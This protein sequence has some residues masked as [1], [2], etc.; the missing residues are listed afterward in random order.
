MGEITLVGT[1]R[2]SSGTIPGWPVFMETRRPRR[3][4]AG[5]RDEG[6]A[7]PNLVC[8]KGRLSGEISGLDSAWMLQQQR[9]PVSR[10]RIHGRPE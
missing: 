7:S 3:V 6:V 1:D 2:A 5:E 10:L 8:P 9:G 4:H